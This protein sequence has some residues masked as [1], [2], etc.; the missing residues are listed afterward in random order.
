[1]ENKDIDAATY[2]SIKKQVKD[3]KAFYLNLSVYGIVIFGLMVI[4]LA[5]DATYLWFL[6]PAFGWGIGVA[7]HGVGV[8]NLSPFLGRDWEQRKI[9]ELLDKEKGARWE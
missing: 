4:N 8:F 7:L 1:M 3:I 5:T 9:Q 6:W 2:Q